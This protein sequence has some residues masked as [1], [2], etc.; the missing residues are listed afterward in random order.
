MFRNNRY[1]AAFGLVVVTL[2]VGGVIAGCNSLEDDF[3]YHLLIGDFYAA[4]CDLVDI[5]LGPAVAPSNLAPISFEAN[6]GQTDARY[7]Y[8]ARGKQHSIL[9]SATE[10]VFELP[11]KKAAPRLVR[12]RL[13]GARTEAQA[14]ALEP[15]SGR[16]NYFI[17][18][19]PNKWVTDIPT[20]GRIAF[21]G[22]YP[23]VDVEY[24]GAGGFV[25]YDF[26]VAPKA[27]P[28]VITIAFNGAEKVEVA[29]DGSLSVQS[30]KRRLQWKK[31]MIYQ[32]DAQG[33]RKAV[34]G[35]YRMGPRGAVGFELGVYDINR[36][37]VIDPVV[38]YATYFGT[39]NT[40]GAARVAAD[41]SGNAYIIGG[42]NA[43]SFAVTPGTVFNPGG[44]LTGD[45]LLAK[46]ASDGHTMIFTTHIG[47]ASTDTGFG[48]ALDSSG[49]IYLTGL[50]FSDDYPH[51]VNLTPNTILP[52]AV[53]FV[54]EL[55]PSG[56]KI[57]YSTLIGGS[58]GDG[59]S[60]IAVDATGSAVIVGGTAS[61]DFPTV[62][63][64]QKSLKS[65]AASQYTADVII[66][67]LSPDGS[68]LTYSTY[69]GG[70]S[71]DF[72]TAV[73]VDAAGN[74]Y[75]TGFTLSPDF[76]VT[77]GAFQTTY[78]GAGGQL[79]SLVYSGDAFVVKMSPTGAM[80]YATFLGGRQDDV[81]AT[82]AIDSQG[83]A[84]IAGATLS[85]DFPMQQPFQAAYK[86]GGGDTRFS[87]GD[88]FV[89]ELNPSGSALLFSSYLGGSL[90][91]RIAALALDPSGN[92]W[93]A[94]H[95]M[96]KDFP[97]TADAPQGTNSGDDGS[98]ANLLRL[99]DAFLVEIGMSRKVIFGTFLGGSSTDW[100][101]GLAVDGLGGVIIA[102]GT[103]SKDFPSSPQA[104]QAKYAGADLGIPTGDAFIA[105]YG[106][107]V[108]SVS[109][110]GVSN[111]ASFASG[112][113]APGEAIL[114]AGANI[115]PA[116]LAG[117]ALAPNG[118][119]ATQVAGA[120]FLFDGVAAPIVFT[121]SGYSSVIVPYEVTGKTST[122]MTATFNGMS[123]P[124]VTL[125]V[126]ASAPGLFSADVSGHG[127]AAAYNSDLTV[128]SAQNPADRGKQ[129]VLFLTGE[130]QTTPTGVDGQITG[131]VIQPV[132]KV[133]VTFGS[134]PA[135]DYK[136]IGEVPGVTAGVLQI[137][138]T[139]PDSTPTGIVPVVVTVGN[140]P[141]Q[142]ALTVAI[143]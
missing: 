125:P 93:V 121:S 110:A 55:S 79:S 29:T 123:S 142:A 100:A 21:S 101:G 58:K 91:D 124:P 71:P 3:W 94:G 74:A 109:I 89:A 28:S 132:Q 120:Q 25:E 138:V 108:S 72:A 139:V 69:L 66:A 141:S 32:Q 92:I 113:V 84:Y 11:E 70:I 118:R 13:E 5:V 9:I 40:D 128:N 68:K 90:D 76:P 116:N 96:S 31:P 30:G 111:A 130:G 51:T 52:D 22:V 85:K 127:Q 37:L 81:G 59:C 34:E 80:V 119:L 27:D 88:G 86:G 19:D 18:N 106:G 39:A 12:A 83:N 82:I 134:L 107:S 117:A 45:V 57:I 6:L 62:N 35:R 15:L 105:R 103:T 43:S 137:N 56:N 60:G 53:C 2:L 47:G 126:V 104:F 49:N 73:A 65:S 7:P 140:A 24:H 8:L 1:T 135:S 44:S 133:S 48:I 46:V 87:G 23:G 63:A 98:G 122:Q 50:T 136:F 143:R 99:G 131:A 95:T 112:A 10:A 38:T 114:I 14:R 41:A 20:F 54:T 115:G 75:V 77:S 67:K 129:I 97:V 16:V 78:A 36:P 102:G 17:G 42:T 26:I 61:P 4:A 64:A 33:E